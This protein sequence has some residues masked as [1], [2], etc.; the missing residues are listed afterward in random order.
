MSTV[1]VRRDG[2]PAGGLQDALHLELS[3]ERTTAITPVRG[4]QSTPAHAIDRE[5]VPP[6]GGY[7]W[8]CVICVFMINAH[9]WGLNFVGFPC[10]RAQV[11]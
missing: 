3:S 6:D 8:I 5:Y 11:P 7:G 10:L 1:S 2:G 9:T 4:L